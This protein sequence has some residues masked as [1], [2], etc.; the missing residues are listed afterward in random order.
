MQNLHALQTQPP[1]RWKTRSFCDEVHRHQVLLCNVNVQTNI[2]S[3]SF[4]KLHHEKSCGVL[5]ETSLNCSRF[6]LLTEAAETGT[7]QQR[8]SR[9]ALAHESWLA[10]FRLCRR[11][12]KVAYRRWN[13]SYAQTERSTLQVQCALAGYTFGIKMSGKV[14]LRLKTHKLGSPG[15]CPVTFS[16]CILRGETFALFL[17]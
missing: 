16:F 14:Y 6:L 7:P 8:S 10:G 15:R 9:T 1:C 3:G 13:T 12:S 4:K 17:L 2:P 5:K 11:S